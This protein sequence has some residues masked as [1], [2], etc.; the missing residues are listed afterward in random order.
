[1]TRKLL[2]NNMWDNN[3][4][5]PLAFQGTDVDGYAQEVAV[6]GFIP[7]IT[8]GNLTNYTTGALEASAVVK[9]S[10]GKL[11]VISGFNTSASDRYIHV[12]NATSLPADTTIPLFTMI[13][14]AGS[15]FGY[16]A[17]NLYGR[18]FSTGIVI[19]TSSTLA[20]LT[21]GAAE[22]HVDVNYL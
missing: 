14:L 22:M 6:S 18:Y 15:T 9:A 10:A 5:I 19:A 8:L 16:T 17:P 20:T 12:F 21:V 4:A 13:A 2:S 3:E 11:F 1:M 7:S